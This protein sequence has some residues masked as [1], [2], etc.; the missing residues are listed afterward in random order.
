MENIQYFMALLA[1]LVIGVFLIKKITGCIFRI[2]IAVIMLAII[3][4]ALTVLHL[5]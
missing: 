4:W 2:V 3:G 1:A 5:L